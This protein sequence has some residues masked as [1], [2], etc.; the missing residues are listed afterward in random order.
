MRTGP[1][2][3]DQAAI[4]IDAMG[5]IVDALGDRLGD[6][7]WPLRQA[8]A[9]SCASRSS[10]CNERAARRRVTAARTPRPTS[11]DHRAPP[12]APHRPALDRVHPPGRLV[13]G[14]RRR[15]QDREVVLAPPGRDR[16]RARDRRL[17][18]RRRA[19][20]LRLHGSFQ[21][22]HPADSRRAVPDHRHAG[23]R[24]RA[25]AH[26][27]SARRTTCSGSSTPRTSSARSTSSTRCSTRRRSRPTSA[28]CTGSGSGTSTRRSDASRHA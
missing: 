26:R 27:A 5:G 2:R 22:R 6:H 14:D 16:R 18:A 12:P 11:G 23:H 28:S 19:H 20:H 21:L 17:D 3:L 10:R 25:G 15:L 4:A 8:L 7:A 1:S 24:A 13:R 9:A